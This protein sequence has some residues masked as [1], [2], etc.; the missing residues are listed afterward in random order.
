M[1]SSLSHVSSCHAGEVTSQCN[2]LFNML[3]L[4]L[5]HLLLAPQPSTW[6]LGGSPPKGTFR[7]P[8]PPG[9]TVG[10]GCEELP[11]RPLH[12]LPPQTP[13]CMDLPKHFSYLPRRPADIPKGDLARWEWREE[14]AKGETMGEGAEGVQAG[15]HL[16]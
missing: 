8:P 6:G 4:G 10:F 15:A 5:Q 12:T 3:V 7:P 16:V 1:V 9:R 11:Q 2:F 14:R 13:S